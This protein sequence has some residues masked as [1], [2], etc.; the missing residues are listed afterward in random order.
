MKN[1]L[2]GLFVALFSIHAN[3]Q[4][5]LDSS[6]FL[7]VG[8][9]FTVIY[10]KN[11]SVVS[12]TGGANHAWDF[13]ALIVDSLSG[14][15]ARAIDKTKYPIDS[16][17]PD[18]NMRVNSV[19]Y[20]R[21]YLIKTQDSVVLDGMANLELAQGTG[22]DFNFKPNVKLIQFPLNYNDSYLSATK[23]DT[24]VDTAI[25]ALNF[26]KIRIEANIQIKSTVEGWGTM[27]SPQGTENCLKLYSQEARKYTVKGHVKGIGWINTPFIT[28][29]DTT[30]TYRWFGK[31]F[32][33]QIAEA[34]TDEKDGTVLTASFLLANKLFAYFTN[35]KE[36]KCYG[37]S[38][39]SLDVVATGGTGTYT[40]KWSHSGSNQTAK[41]TNLAAGKYT[42]TVT[43]PG[44]STNFVTTYDLGQPDSMSISV[45]STK[46]EGP[47]PNTGE[48]EISVIGGTGNYTYAW[49]SS[50]SVLKKAS[51]LPGGANTVT[52]T[53]ANGCKKDT[54]IVIGSTVS[55]N[56]IEASTVLNLWPNPAKHYINLEGLSG[57]ENE[58]ILL[59]SRGQIIT[60][61]EI[62]NQIALQLNI[63]E[64]PE[65]MYIVQLKGENNLNRV[66]RFVKQ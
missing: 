2:L 65:G 58:L 10:A 46:D 16:M 12:V 17:F 59:N 9:T 36:P 31:N 7:S 28:Q 42:V 19:S 3:A 15:K 41:A 21:A 50:S 13:S 61:Y 56:E 20:G 11:P 34:T 51:D 60:K 1:A 8:D 30:H 54:T 66:I 49:D 55:L 47:L 48:I 22:I 52:V 18:A 32:G 40:Y 5:T 23:I 57:L 44:A 64:L 38:N 62:T 25:T 14:A 39:G 26:D 27:K 6:D 35:A 37:E 29:E 53:D 24:I 45:I 43:D 4:I 33:Y 63:S